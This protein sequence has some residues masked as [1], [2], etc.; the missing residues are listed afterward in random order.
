MRQKTCVKVPKILGTK[1]LKP[2]NQSSKDY[3]TENQF[4]RPEASRILGKTGNK[5][6]FQL[7]TSTVDLIT[8]A[9]FKIHS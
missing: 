3:C 5:V 2:W 1:T 6:N 9:N 8:V 4:A 7:Q